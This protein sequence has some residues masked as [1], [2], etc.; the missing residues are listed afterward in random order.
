ML[1]RAVKLALGDPT[2]EIVAATSVGTV[3]SSPGLLA[4][5]RLRLDVCEQVT[6]QGGHST[7]C[8]ALGSRINGIFEQITPKTG[9]ADISFY[10]SSVHIVDLC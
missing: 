3:F 2:R 8:R 1:R 4:L 10:E 9:G 5:L 7:V 6:G